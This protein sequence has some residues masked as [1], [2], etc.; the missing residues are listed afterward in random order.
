M[1]MG[2]HAYQSSTSM[3]IQS[4]FDHRNY[5]YN[6]QYICIN[7]EANNSCFVSM[8]VFYALGV[9]RV[10]KDLHVLRDCINYCE[11]LHSSKPGVF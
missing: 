5:M 11:H 9:Q 6:T 10:K 2:V 4:D 8:Y 1:I 3:H 7:G